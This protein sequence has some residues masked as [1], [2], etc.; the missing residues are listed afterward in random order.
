MRRPRGTA[1][2]RLLIRGAE[3]WGFELKLSDAPAMT[4]SL[5]MVMTDL[6]LTRAWLIYPGKRRY[7]V[8][9]HI[10]ALPLRDIETL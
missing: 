6:K 9:P 4:R 1:L 7:D 2:D 10:T 5:P 8:A 3:R